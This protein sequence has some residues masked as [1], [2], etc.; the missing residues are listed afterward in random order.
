MVVGYQPLASSNAASNYEE[1]ISIDLNIDGNLPAYGSIRVFINLRSIEWL[2]AYSSIFMDAPGFKSIQVWWEF[3]SL[4]SNLD[5]AVVFDSSQI[6]SIEEGR[7]IAETIMGKIENLWGINFSYTGHSVIVSQ[8]QGE[9][10][11]E[12]NYSYKAEERS[13][14]KLR[15]ILL[16]YCPFEGFGEI[17]HSMN[18]W[19]YNNV[20]LNLK[21]DEQGNPVWDIRFTLNYPEYFYVEANQEYTVSLKELTGCAEPIQPVSGSSNSYLSLS[22]PLAEHYQLKIIR[23]VPEQMRVGWDFNYFTKYLRDESVDDLSLT[24]SFVPAQAP[25]TTLFMGLLAAGAIAVTSIAGCVL[26]TRMRAKPR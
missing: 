15:E 26:I 1:Q 24:F 18:F 17:P 10:V 13:L 8:M 7:L 3:R 20:S 22:V 6:K 9:S 25:P 5:V 19:G 16:H 23:H 4:G 2:S 14:Q 11:N 12:T 21:L